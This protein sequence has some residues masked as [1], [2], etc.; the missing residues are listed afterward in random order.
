MQ[1]WRII[2]VIVA[3]PL[4]ALT[5]CGA[6]TPDQEAGLTISRTPPAPGDPEQGQELFI[7]TLALT[8]SPNCSSCHV[9]EP[10]AEAI[11]GPSLVGIAE[12]AGTRVGGVSAEEYLWI[13]MVAPNEHIVEGYAAGIMPRTYALYMSEE[14]LADLLAYMLTLD[15]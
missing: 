9:V 15:S 8:G 12:S 5:G 1:L 13:A 6:T 7:N 3:M 14:Q 2:I 11:V 10:G 4:F